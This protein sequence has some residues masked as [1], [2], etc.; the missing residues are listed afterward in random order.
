[1]QVSDEVNVLLAR[2][3]GVVVLDDRWDRVVHR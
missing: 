2:E 3:S 1:M